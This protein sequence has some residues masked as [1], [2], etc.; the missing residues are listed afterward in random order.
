MKVFLSWSGDLSHKVACCIR[1]WLPSVLQY[2]T[3]YVSSEDIDKGA[4]W[5]TDIAKEL[6]ASA[7]GIII[8]T[9]AN[10]D[11]PWVSFEAGAL[12][13][14]LE[15][16][17]VSPLLYGLKR[18]EVQGPLLQFQSTIISKEDIFKLLS[19]INKS[20]EEDARIE[21]NRLSTIFDVWWPELESELA[22]IPQPNQTEEPQ[23]EP[24][25]SDSNVLEE[26][27]DLVRI[28]QKILS[29]PQEILP[30]KYLSQLLNSRSRKRSP[31][32][33]PLINDSADFLSYFSTELN[34]LIEV[35]EGKSRPELSS[36]QF[37]YFK[38]LCVQAKRFSQEIRKHQQLYRGTSND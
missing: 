26:I 14:S 36:S 6:D 23:T 8:V 4:R 11:A 17:R 9:K 27:L 25:S 31:A 34:E 20:A 29:D 37:E 15:K 16:S 21:P 19:S 33:H 38:S 1:D 28:Q 30:P 5:S 22:N 10:I 3:P 7:F 35:L 12:S 32:I 13:K 18:S 2:T 24:R